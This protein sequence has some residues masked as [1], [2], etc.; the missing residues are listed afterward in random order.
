[1]K[2]AL[3]HSYPTGLIAAIL[4]GQVPPFPRQ[5]I[6]CFPRKKSLFPHL[7]S[8]PAQ[9]IPAHVSDISFRED[10]FTPWAGLGFLFYV[11][12]NHPSLIIVVIRLNHLKFVTCDHFLA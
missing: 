7:I 4:K 5:P 10:F 11:L 2:L 9:P 12:S 6:S 1:M 8:S 3:S